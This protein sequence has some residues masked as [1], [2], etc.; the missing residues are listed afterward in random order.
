MPAII[1][2]IFQML[3]RL[4]RIVMVQVI[5]VTIVLLLQIQTSSIQ[6]MMTSEMLAII[7]PM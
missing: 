5:Y 1:A 7:A 4:T 3:T 2:R 6:M